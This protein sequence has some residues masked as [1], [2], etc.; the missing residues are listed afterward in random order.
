VELSEP[1]IYNAPPTIARFFADDS[2]VRCII[3]PFASGKSSGCSVEI[4]RRAMAQE[5]GPDGIRRSRGAIIRNSYRELSDTTRR[6]VEEWVPSGIREWSESNASMLIKFNDVECEVL[7]RALDTPDDVRKLLSLELTWAWI[8]EAKEI[9]KAVLDVL[10]GRINR[11]P[12]MRQG[13][14]TWTGIWMDTN[15][16]DD[17]HW[18]YKLFEEM[19]PPEH[20]M[21]HQPGGL[22]PD[23]ENIENLKGGRAYYERMC[24]GKTKEWIDVFVHGKYGFVKDGRP[25]YPEYL[26]ELHTMKEPPKWLGST[27]YLGMDF[28]LTPAIVVLQKTAFH[29]WQAIDEFVSEDMGATRFSSF[30][31]AELA[32]TY[33]GARF[34]GWGDPAGSQRSQVDETTPYQVVQAAGLPIDPAHTNDFVRRREAVANALTR[35]TLTGV[36]SL[37]VSPKC[38]TLRK[39]M[40]GGYCFR[41]MQVA[42]SER[43]KD[44][45][46]KGPFSHVAEALQYALVGEGED[47]S[48][49][50][51]TYGSEDEERAKP[52]INV[53]TSLR[54]RGYR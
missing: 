6:T 25:V 29:Q 2:M 35:L 36:P 30:V 43:F 27:L 11:Y 9:P 17:D 3:G 51:G 33:P 12:S 20:S 7:F 39:A 40:N 47:R 34:R 18:I 14:P 46:D 54:S 15:P 22:S 37:V 13:G 21:Y 1:V 42:G 28:G 4:L 53:K 32:R 23:A 31:K 50:D 48:A 24:H 45:P 41:R 16:P 5:P 49:L 38:K 44:A 10:Q 8:N 19:R 26:D 52:R